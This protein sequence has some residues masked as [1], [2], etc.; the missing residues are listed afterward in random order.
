MNHV[1]VAILPYLGIE[2]LYRR[3]PGYSTTAVQQD[4]TLI[5]A[6]LSLQ[7][8]DDLLSVPCSEEFHNVKMSKTFSFTEN[9]F[10]DAPYAS[11]LYT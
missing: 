9:F 2:T 1:P 4:A 8:F 3:K 11:V 6:T 7:I 5:I 10:A